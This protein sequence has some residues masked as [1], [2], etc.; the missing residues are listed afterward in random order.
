MMVALRSLRARRRLAIA[1][2][3]ALLAG[4]FVLASPPAHAESV[5][6]TVAGR[7]DNRC[8]VLDAARAGYGGSAGDRFTGEPAASA[9]FN[10]RMHSVATDPTGGALFVADFQRNAVHRIDRAG[11]ATIRTILAGDE[12]STV[13]A[14]AVGPRGSQLFVLHRLDAGGF[15]IQAATLSGGLGNS[16]ELQSAGGSSGP[17]GLA[18]DA[19]GNVY[20]AESFEAGRILRWDGSSSAVDVLVESVRRPEAVAVSLIGAVYYTEREG[21][22]ISAALKQVGRAGAIV[23]GLE[24]PRG[25]A[26]DAE[27][28]DIYIAESGAHRISRWGGLRTTIAGD[29][30]TT[31]KGT[32]I[33]DGAARSVHLHSPGGLALTIDGKSLFFVDIDA[34]VIR[35]V[36]IEEPA[37]AVTTSIAPTTVTTA[38]VVDKGGGGGSPVGPGGGT[39][40]EPV[41]DR[42]VAPGFEQQPAAVDGGE[43]VVAPSGND[44]GSSAGATAGARTEASGAGAGNAAGSP[45]PP[46]PEA[47]AAPGPAPGVEGEL[48]A[49]VAQTGTATPPAPEPGVA[50]FG[51]ALPAPA[52]AP[53]APAQPAA[54]VVG[55][56][57]DPPQ[58]AVRYAMV[59]R[60]RQPDHDPWGPALLGVG[61]L[62]LGTCFVLAL[63]P[64][65]TRPTARPNPAWAGGVPPRRA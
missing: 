2:L 40:P 31:P 14:V 65:P 64:G 15:R 22:G 10:Y 26:V 33:V 36:N 28:G 3:L 56:A 47:A 61:A 4:L 8:T 44:G 6:T 39:G 32:A 62:A 46:G 60:E 38:P 18:A 24:R 58:G 17:F 30:A 42:V 52:P 34:C 21:E 11:P 12:A 51:A 63:R 1:G 41:V 7:T 43:T 37:P 57:G 45:P 23:S 35:M 59:A 48:P 29:G 54:G 20:V 19:S 49:V 25:L 50:T 55:P 27:S 53:G 5:V 9:D 13:E 16:V